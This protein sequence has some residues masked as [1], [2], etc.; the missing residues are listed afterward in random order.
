MNVTSGT[1][2]MQQ[3]PPKDHVGP[4]PNG[5]PHPT[6]SCGLSPPQPFWGK[7]AW[8]TCVQHLLGVSCPLQSVVSSGWTG[9]SK[10][11]SPRRFYTVLFTL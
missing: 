11:S 2:G 10:D 9:H 8:D 6:P 4:L 3:L 5:S 7:R 1:S